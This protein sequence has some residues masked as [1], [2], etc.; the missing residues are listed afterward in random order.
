MAAKPR[1]CRCI[2][3]ICFHCQQTPLTRQEIIFFTT[4]DPSVKKGLMTSLK[5]KLCL[6]LTIFR[7][8]RTLVEKC[9]A[10]ATWIA[11][12]LHSYWRWRTWTPLSRANSVANHPH[13]LVPSQF[14]WKL[15]RHYHAFG[16]AE[17]PVGMWRTQLW[18]KSHRSH[19]TSR[20]TMQ[21]WCKWTRKKNIKKS[22]H[23]F[24]FQPEK[25]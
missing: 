13:A 24:S 21:L 25:W 12:Q 14:A 4:I 9:F 5:G 3:E 23:G 17:E 19:P 22:H 6:L 8:A 7:F 11:S 20:A 1:P 10:I 16:N 18:H 15:W 2:K